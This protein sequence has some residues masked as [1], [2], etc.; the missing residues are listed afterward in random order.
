MVTLMYA[1]GWYMVTLTV[2][3]DHVVGEPVLEAAAHCRVVPF[4]CWVHICVVR[5]IPIPTYQTHTNKQTCHRQHIHHL[6]TTTIP[7]IKKNPKTIERVG[8]GK[9][10]RDSE[11]FQ[12]LQ[13]AIVPWIKC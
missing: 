8:W 6:D 4:V 1:R 9:E 10:R 2:D 12:I 5:D 11:H 7:N 3:A 13:C